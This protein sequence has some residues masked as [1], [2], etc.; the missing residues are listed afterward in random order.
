MK[1][2][3]GDSEDL[4]DEIG[5]GTHIAELVLTLAPEAIL[6]VAKVAVKRVM[7]Q[8]DTNLI[9]KAIQWALTQDVDII[10]LSLGLDLL[11]L[12]L[13]AAINKAIAAG[14][15]VLA[16]AGN[17]GNNKPRAHPGRNRNVLCIHASNGKGKD[18]GISPRALDNDDNFM[19]LGTAIP[20]NWKGKEV[21]KSGTSFATAVAAAIAANALAIISRDG[22]LNEDQVK[23]LYSCDGMRLI[24]AL[25]SSQSD[26]GY[27]YVAPWNLWVGDRSSE[28]IQHQILEVLRR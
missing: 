5:H 13:D 11:D 25:L 7:P 19:T 15:I 16:A 22:L 21:V 10:S 9:S 26:N 18:G 8:E 6:C 2:F 28:L 1:S 4:N 24:F 23:R 20:L 27:K 12:E 3:K 17:D 14:K